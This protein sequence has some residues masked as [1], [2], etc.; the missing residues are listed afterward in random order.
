MFLEVSD[1]Q[2][3]GE[4]GRAGVRERLML[5]LMRSGL[6]KT[7]LA[8]ELGVNR[9]VLNSWFVSG[10][11]SPKWLN[12]VC[13]HFG[14]SKAWL[15]N[16]EGPGPAAPQGYSVGNIE[17]IDN[18]VT[19]EVI[20]ADSVRIPEYHVVFCCGDGAD[21]PA[22]EE[23]TDTL[24]AY[25]RRSFFDFRGINPR[26]CV[27]IK[28]HG[29]SMEPLINDGD[30]LLIDRSNDAV[31]IAVPG[32]IYAL[33]FDTQLMVKRIRRLED[34]TVE[35]TSENPSFLPIRLSPE[36]AAERLIVIG[37]VVERSGCVF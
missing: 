21:E 13:A 34:G 20:P 6:N 17:V 9:S 12:V 33:I 32:G 30:M 31:S 1:M 15:L 14:V 7:R 23:C 29:R 28:A 22:F 5:L 10:V 25:Y 18:T 35:L 36:E 27:R 11:V 4:A 19:P 2:N 8:A 37:H 24:P 3:P 16:G 26:T